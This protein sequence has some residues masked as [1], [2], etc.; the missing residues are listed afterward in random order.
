MMESCEH[1]DCQHAQNMA[2]LIESDSPEIATIDLAQLIPGL[3]PWSL[4]CADASVIAF[5]KDYE[6]GIWY[7]MH[8]SEV[9]AADIVTL[10]EGAV[11]G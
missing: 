10:L 6:S 9:T 4:N 8:I 5:R 11:R 1:P 7:A 2:A 3:R